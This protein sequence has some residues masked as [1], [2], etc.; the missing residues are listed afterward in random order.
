MVIASLL[1]MWASFWGLSFLQ[2]REAK[3]QILEMDRVEVE[4][5]EAAVEADEVYSEAKEK[6][7]AVFSFVVD[8]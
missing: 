4:F 8:Q 1:L 6:T 7:E 5:Y 2:A 3:A